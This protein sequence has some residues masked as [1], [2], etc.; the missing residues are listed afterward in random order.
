MIGG[1]ICQIESTYVYSYSF[2]QGPDV[3]PQHLTIEKR[4]GAE[5]ILHDLGTSEGTLVNHCRVSGASVKLNCGDIIKLGPSKRIYESSLMKTCSFT[6]KSNHDFDTL[7]DMYETP[8][9]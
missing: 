1:I 7:D 8:S 2:F 5:Y 9:V 3:A 6:N 4:N